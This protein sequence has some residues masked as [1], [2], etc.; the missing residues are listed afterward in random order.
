[1]TIGLVWALFGQNPP[2][3]NLPTVSSQKLCPIFGAGARGIEVTIYVQLMHVIHLYLP[4]PTAPSLQGM[5][6]FQ[7]KRPQAAMSVDDPRVL[8]PFGKRLI[9]ASKN[10][11][12]C[13]WAGNEGYGGIGSW[14]WLRRGFKFLRHP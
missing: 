14:Y 10:L 9:S 13:N 4:H 7:P 3:S 5:V 2:Q 6:P 11:M 1:M 12:T 8:E